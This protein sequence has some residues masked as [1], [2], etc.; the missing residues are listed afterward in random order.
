M[1]I[2]VAYGI[3]DWVARGNI[4]QFTEKLII[5]AQKY[6]HVI[7]RARPTHNGRGDMEVFD[8]RVVC[9]A[10]EGFSEGEGPK[11]DNIRLARCFLESLY[12]IRDRIISEGGNGNPY[13]AG[14]IPRESVFSFLDPDQL[15]KSKLSLADNAEAF[16][17]MLALYQRGEPAPLHRI[18]D[19]EEAIAHK[20]RIALNLDRK[21]FLVLDHHHF[22]SLNR[23]PEDERRRERDRYLLYDFMD[24]EK[25][26]YV[27]VVPALP[28]F[29]PGENTEQLKFDWEMAITG[30]QEG[31]YT[32]EPWLAEMNRANHHLNG[33]IDGKPE[34]R[35]R[36]EKVRKD[37]GQRELKAAGNRGDVRAEIDKT[38]ESYEA[39]LK[40]IKDDPEIKYKLGEFERKDKREQDERMGRIKG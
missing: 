20:L 19:R 7:A 13:F 15:R 21:I 39:E 2:E 11:Y 6:Q 18:D 10:V 31:C 40:R 25:I 17:E 29:Y 34:L 37:G 8:P 26:P 24:G 28:K 27:V 36:L 1:S 35:E 32:Y 3:G 14:L 23:H 38:Y 30:G 4:S 33:L 5:S 16:Q 9:V 22:L 12:E